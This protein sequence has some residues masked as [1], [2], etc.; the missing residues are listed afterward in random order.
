MGG[1]GGQRLGVTSNGKRYP[2]HNRS[3]QVGLT[4]AAAMSAEGR[5]CCGAA[6]TAAGSAIVVGEK[7]EDG[8]TARGDSSSPGGDKSWE[9]EP[10]GVNSSIFNSGGVKSLRRENWVVENP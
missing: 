8:R 7:T 6:G 1:G 2:Q 9:M 10:C 4:G 5:S 3:V